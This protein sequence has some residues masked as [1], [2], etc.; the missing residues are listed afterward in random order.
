MTL[1][2]HLACLLLGGAVAL[3]AVVV[4]RTAFPSGLLLSVV[5]TFA[6][7]WWLGRSAHPRTAASY[8][9]GWLVVLGLVVAGRPEGDFALAGDLDGYTLLGAGFVMVLVAVV[10]V[11]AR[12]PPGP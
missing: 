5:T 10:A 6:V 4:H 11:A 8:A 12:R 9:V 7:A 2:R 1:L 3:A